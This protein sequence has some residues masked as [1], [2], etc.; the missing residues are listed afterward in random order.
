[1]S[2]SIQDFKYK[3]GHYAYANTWNLKKTNYQKLLKSLEM[4]LVVT[5]SKQTNLCSLHK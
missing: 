5:P 3:K 2:K 1:M 4:Q